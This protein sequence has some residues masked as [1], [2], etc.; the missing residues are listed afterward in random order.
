MARRGLEHRRLHGAVDQHALAGLVAQRAGLGQLARAQEQAVA[1]G[2]RG[3]L[4]LQ[5]Q[6][7]CDQPRGQRAFAVADQADDGHA[8]GAVA[9][10]QVLG[11][12][13]AHRLG[14]AHGRL[15]VH[16]QAGAGVDLDDGA[17]LGAKRLGDVFHHQVDAGD[18]QPHH[19][20]GQRHLLGDVGVHLAGDVDGHVAGALHHG[21][22]AA[23]QHAVRGQALALQQQQQHGVA[24]AQGFQRQVF[25]F[26]AARVGVDLGVDQ[27][28]DGRFAI[29]ADVDDLA[30]RGR[31]HLAAHHQQAV[32]LA[33]DEAFDDDLGALG[34]G[35]GEGVHDFLARLQV[36]RY[37]ARVVA[38][39]RLDDHGQADV[40]GGFPGVFGRLDR[41]A[42]GHGHAGGGYQ[43][44]GQV[45]VARDAF[46]DG[47]GAVGLGR[48]D[49]ALR[50]A[51]AQLH[52]VAVV[53]A[54]VRDAA[55]GG[56]IDDAGGAG[57]QALAIHQVGQPGDGGGDVVGAVVD[58]RHDQ[59][60]GGFDGQFADRLVAG[61][62]DHLVDAVFARHA[63]LAKAGL[64]AGLGL[65]L[66][67][68]VLQDVAG[69]GA[70]AQAHQKAAAPADAAAVLDQAGQP[71][72][73]PLVEAGQ[74]VGGVILQLADVDDGLD[75]GAVG[76]D[77]GAAQVRHAA[78]HDV[79]ES[80]LR[81]CR[82]GRRHGSADAGGRGIQSATARGAVLVLVDSPHRAVLAFSV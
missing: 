40:L 29:A 64:H 25:F 48:P 19:A 60:A 41:A 69:P 5:L 20:G 9:G 47:A 17:A 1:A 32:F 34:L 76:P 26:A 71:G 58:G 13:L 74:G 28:A 18:V 81:R 62:D 30:A 22:F 80:A 38:V 79:G 78:D 15:Q 82:R 7:R 51:V 46:G 11:N 52:Q 55:F 59:V 12:G 54:D 56:G 70:V 57:A 49:A 2:Q 31:Y 27:L 16:Q 3:L 45:L 39:G 53:Q 8:A 43:L 23:R 21:G 61:A 10:E 44:L 24:R 73:E 63:R 65:Q 37:A 72:G 50:G 66:Q 67:R 68:H 6:Q 42:L 4:A 35:G 36:Q 75:D 33:G 14:A 77:V